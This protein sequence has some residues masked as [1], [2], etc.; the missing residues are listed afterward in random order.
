MGFMM[1]NVQR[2]GDDDQTV[3]GAMVVV[4]RSC[5]S[6][7]CSSLDFLSGLRKEIRRVVE[8]AEEEVAEEDQIPHELMRFKLKTLLG[9]L[10]GIKDHRFHS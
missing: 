1:K 5:A 10:P 2:E 4:A 7:V 8:V 9:T 6:V 3:S